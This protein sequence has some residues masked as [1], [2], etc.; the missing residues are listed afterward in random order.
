MG[1]VGRL[2]CL[3]LL[4]GGGSVPLA[5]QDGDNIGHE[6]FENVSAHFHTV[7]LVAGLT[8]DHW[9]GRQGRWDTSLRA[10]DALL[11]GTA[12]TIALKAITLSP[13]PDTSTRNSFPSGHTSS[14]FAVATVQAAYHPD[15]AV[16][17]YTGAALIGASRVGLG[18]HRWADVIG[19]AAVGFLAGRWSLQSDG[20]LLAPLWGS[21]PGIAAAIRF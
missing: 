11:V 16:Y 12:A 15:E 8:L 4:M 5:A 9:P 14:A 17:W 18:R 19:G 13:R 21:G 1:R 2:V 10:A 7:F 6:I 20:L 3:A